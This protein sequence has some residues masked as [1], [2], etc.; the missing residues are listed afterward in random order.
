MWNANNDMRFS[1]LTL[2]QFFLS[3]PNVTIRETI[4]LQM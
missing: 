3:N 2:K 4:R 1:D